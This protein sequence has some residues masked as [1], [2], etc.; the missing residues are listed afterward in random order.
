M[1]AKTVMLM[2]LGMKISGLGN[3]YRYEIKEV[4]KVLALQTGMQ[5]TPHRAAALPAG[6]GYRK[7]LP[8]QSGAGGAPSVQG[9]VWRPHEGGQG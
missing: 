6:K 7:G 2:P 9:A 3:R 4:E 5:N 8:P 1:K